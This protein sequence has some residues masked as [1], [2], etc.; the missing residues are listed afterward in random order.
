[1][2]RSPGTTAEL[3]RFGRREAGVFK[4]TLMMQSIRTL[5]LD[6]AAAD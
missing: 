1:M 2:G 3:P 6:L 4:I 5:L